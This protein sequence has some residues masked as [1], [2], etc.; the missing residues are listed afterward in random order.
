MMRIVA[1][2]LRPSSRAARARSSRSVA[3][4]LTGL[5]AGRSGFDLGQPAICQSASCSSQL[6]L[7]ALLI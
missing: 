5:R 6:Q 3:A 1:Q 7:E 4:A 2:T